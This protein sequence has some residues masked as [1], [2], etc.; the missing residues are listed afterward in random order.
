MVLAKVK[1]EAYF[2]YLSEI[3]SEKPE[4]KNMT[5][6]DRTLGW[7]TIISSSFCWHFHTFST[8]PTPTM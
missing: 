2:Y 7:R 3:S 4:R 5:P 1:R 6:V 8:N